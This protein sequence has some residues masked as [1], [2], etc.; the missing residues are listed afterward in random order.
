MF[1]V[2]RLCFDYR[3]EPIHWCAVFFHV[4]FFASCH[5]TP[6]NYCFHFAS[7]CD[8]DGTQQ[9]LYSLLIF[10][11]PHKF[12]MHV[13]KIN[14]LLVPGMDEKSTSSFLLPKFQDNPFPSVQ[15]EAW[16]MWA[17]LLDL[18]S[19][20]CGGVHF[21]NFSSL[22][23]ARSF[24]SRREKIT[25]NFICI[26]SS[27]SCHGE[28]IVKPPACPS[29]PSLPYLYIGVLCKCSCSSLLKWPL[30]VLGLDDKAIHVPN[31]P[32][33]VASLLLSNYFKWAPLPP[34]I[35]SPNSMTY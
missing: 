22:G 33:F 2:I 1:M 7:P 16:Q 18:I 13:I 35:F 30:S 17:Q 5:F 14:H 21:S 10:H 4:V 20:L 8:E 28:V 11:S 27:A 31:H 3:N 26:K 19:L 12:A 6:S 23:P 34:L 24:G 29:K 9:V 15:K 32:E 25:S